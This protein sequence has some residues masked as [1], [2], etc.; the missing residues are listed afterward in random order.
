MNGYVRFKLRNF[1]ETNLIPASAVFNRGGK[2]YVIVV[3]EQKAHFVP[4]RV[5]VND[6]KLAKVSMVRADASGRESLV[7]L[8]GNEEIVGSRQGELDEGQLLAPVLKEW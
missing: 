2:Q 6:G 4:V 3:Q 7:E 8:T 1:G 5:Q